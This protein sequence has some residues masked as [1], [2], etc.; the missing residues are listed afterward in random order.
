MKHIFSL[1][2]TILLGLFGFGWVALSAQESESEFAV[3]IDALQR[4]NRVLQ[5][6]LLES[7]ARQATPMGEALSASNREVEKFRKL[8]ADLLLKVDGLGLESLGS[9]D[10]LRDRAVKAISEIEVHKEQGKRLEVQLLKLSELM[11]RYLKA[12]TVSDIEI[13]A[14]VEVELREVDQLLGFDNLHQSGGV[15]LADI[16]E[17]KVISFKDDL[18]LAVLN[19]GKL[20]GVKIG[21]PMNVFRRDRLVGSVVVVDVRD[22]ICGVLVQELYAAGDEIHVQDRAEPRTRSAS[23]L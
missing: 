3:V 18:Q 5:R 13:R 17:A 15:E 12:S 20:S 4:Q 21:M 23:D 8:Y 19:V 2:R 22:S 6:Q 11:I 9:P 14:E 7:E 16:K 10:L 1:L